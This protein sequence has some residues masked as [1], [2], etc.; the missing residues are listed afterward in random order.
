MRLILLFL[1]LLPS[2]LQAQFTTENKQTA[3][4]YIRN[5]LMGPGVV[6]GNIRHVGMIGGLGQFNADSTIIGVKSGLVL[7][8]GNAD[9]I[10]GPNDTRSFTSRGQLPKDYHD[11]VH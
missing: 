8:T 6:V 9:S 5:V 11:A 1:L 3:E 2:L 10:K 4:F 7:S